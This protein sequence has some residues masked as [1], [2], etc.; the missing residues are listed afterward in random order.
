MKRHPELRPLSE[1]HHHV[2]VLALQIR[3]AAESTGPN[4]DQELRKLAESLLRFWEETGQTHFVEEEQ[5][6][7]PRYARHRRL[8]EDPEI[9]RMLADHAAIRAQMEDLKACLG[10]TFAPESLIKLGLTLRDHVR[11]EEDRI[12]PRIE[13]VL[14]EAELNS[15]GSQLTRLHDGAH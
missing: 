12:F 13:K 8:D 7:L 15:V 2:L 11:L 3:Q 5:V 6:L 9:M 4:R 14:S 10:A 1:H